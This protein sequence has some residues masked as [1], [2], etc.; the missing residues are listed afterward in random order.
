MNVGLISAVQQSDSVIQYI[1]VPFYIRF[2]YGLSQDIKYSSLCYTVGPCC[3]RKF[4]IGN[5]LA[6][7]WL[8]LCL[9]TANGLGSI[10]GQGTKILQT[11]MNGQKKT[12]S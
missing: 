7:Q 5:S 1:Y 2:H 3:L 10:P 11:S 9:F 12:K 4:I 6:R 8:E